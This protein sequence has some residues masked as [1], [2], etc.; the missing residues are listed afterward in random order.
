MNHN[1]HIERIKSL[2]VIGLTILLILSNQT[3]LLSAEIKPIQ[4]ND[5]IYF[6]FTF[7]NPEITKTNDGVIFSLLNCDLTSFPGSPKIPFKSVKILIPQNKDLDSIDVNNGDSFLFPETYMLAH[8]QRAIPIGNNIDNSYTPQNLDIYNSNVEFPGHFY[9]IISIE[10]MC[11]FKVLFVNIYPVQ[12]IPISGEIYLYPEI[13]LTVNLKTNDDN[14]IKNNNFRMYPKDVERIEKLVDNSDLINT[15]TFNDDISFILSSEDSFVD[16]ADTYEYVVITNKELRDASGMD[17]NFWDLI[18]SKLDKGMNATIVTVE[19]IVNCSTYWWDGAFGDGYPFFNDTA[20]KIRNFIK[21]AYNN[22]ETLYVL[23]GGD[24]DATYL[25]DDDCNGNTCPPYPSDLSG[26]NIIPPRNLMSTLVFGLPEITPSDLYYGALNG[27]WNKPENPNPVS[28]DLSINEPSVHGSSEW[29]LDGP[30]INVTDYLI[31]SDS[32]QWTCTNTD[33]YYA[34]CIFNIDDPFM[35]ISGKS[36]LN[37]QINASDNDSHLRNVIINSNDGSEISFYAK[38]LG[39][40]ASLWDL[41]ENKWQSEHLFLETFV[42]ISDFNWSNVISITIEIFNPTPEIG[43]T[44]LLDGV[45]FSEYVDDYWGEPDEADL[46]NEVIIGRAPVDSALEVSNFVNKTLAYDSSDGEDFLRDVWMVGEQVYFGGPA[47]WGANYKDEIKYGS[48]NYGYSTSGISVDYDV[49]TIYDRDKEFKQGLIDISSYCGND[50]VQL[51]FRAKSDNNIQGAGFYI[52]D[53][54]IICDDNNVVFFDDMENEESEWQIDGF[55]ENWERGT[56]K[57]IRIWARTDEYNRPIYETTSLIGFSGAICWGTN[58]D[59]LYENDINESILSPIFDL[60][61]FSTGKLYFSYYYNFEENFD[62]GYVEISVDN[63][64]TW[65]ILKNYTSDSW[66]DKNDLLKAFNDNNP[67]IINHLG[68]GNNYHVMK[69]DEPLKMRSQRNCSSCTPYKTYGSCHDITKNLT[70]IKPFFMYSQACLPGAF[71]N[72]YPPHPGGVHDKS[73]YL[74]NDSIIEYMLTDENG[75]F[76]CV[77]NTRFGLGAPSTNAPS[78]YFDREFFDALFSE[79]NK[80]FGEAFTDSLKYNIGRINNYGIRYCFYETTY[81]GDPE[82]CIKNP[83]PPEHDLCIENLTNPDYGVIEEDVVFNITVYNRGINEENNV[84]INFY[85]ND[86]LIDSIII[87]NIDSFEKYLL[88]FSYDTVIPGSYHLKFEVENV[89]GESYIYDN[90]R[91]FDFTIYQIQPLKVVILES[92]GTSFNFMIYDLL[93]LRWQEFIDTPVIIDYISLAHNDITLDDL[94]STNAD[95]LVIDWALHTPQFKMFDFEYSDE[96]LDAI[97]DYINSGH[98][99]I[100]TRDSF[101]GNNHRLKPFVGL[102]PDISIIDIYKSRIGK[103]NVQQ[104]EHPMFNNLPNN[105]LSKAKSCY[106]RNDTKWDEYDIDDGTIMALSDNLKGIIVANDSRVYMSTWIHMDPVGNVYVNDND[107]QLFYNTILYANDPDIAN[108]LLV[109]ANLPNEGYI[110]VP[111]NFNCT[112]K[113]GVEPYNFSWDFGD[114]YNS[115]SQNTTHIYQS[116][117]VYNV[118]LTVTDTTGN[119]S[120]DKKQVFISHQPYSTLWVNQDYGETTPGWQ[121]DHFNTIQEAIDLSGTFGTIHVYNGTYKENLM[122]HKSV[123]LIG[124]DKNNT[125]IDGCQQ[126]HVINISA[127]Y[128]NISEFTIKNSSIGQG[129]NEIGG[130]Y[131][132]SKNLNISDNIILNNDIGIKISNS[133]NSL[134]NNNT[135]LNNKRYGIILYDTKFTTVINN[136][137]SKNVF[138]GLVLLASPINNIL[139]NQ[140]KYNSGNGIYSLFSYANIIENNFISYN[141]ADGVTL[142]D[143]DSNIIFFNNISNNDGTSIQIYESNQNNIQNN[144]IIKN[145]NGGFV[146]TFS[147]LNVLSKNVILNNDDLGI[148]LVGE[149]NFPLTIYNNISNNLIK[150]NGNNG[151]I[152]DESYENIIYNNTILNHSLNGIYFE[153]SDDNQITNNTI[154]Y[155]QKGVKIVANSYQNKIQANFLE[156]NSDGIFIDNSNINTIVKNKIRN[157]N[158]GIYLTGSDNSMIGENFIV[159][160]SYGIYFCD[161]SLYNSVIWNVIKNNQMYGMYLCGESSDNTIY[162]NTFSNINNAY[163][164]VGYNQYYIFIYY[165]NHPINQG[166]FWQDYTGVDNDGDDIGDTPYNISGGNNKDYYPLIFPRAFPPDNLPPDIPSKASG[167]T[168]KLMANALYLYS[169]VTNDTDRDKVYYYFNWG[170]KSGSGWIGPYPSGQPVALSHAWRSPGTYHIRVKAKD[171]YGEITPFSETL[172]INVGGGHIIPRPSR[173]K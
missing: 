169:S 120:T 159:N 16:P 86:E 18:D 117:D 26:D 165:P 160:N 151:I 161:M 63:G 23:L 110:N 46:L 156:F 40:N 152:F 128:V 104:P 65:N 35:D 137:I 112:V 136:N 22:W 24:G 138:E 83:P 130:I 62:F 31:G 68:H 153:G 126:N 84:K 71:D 87:E 12:Y 149:N 78:Q 41:P 74:E 14:S 114:G 29:F 27:S 44:I 166:N 129:M 77:A 168:Q 55:S 111:I 100:V 72:V 148:Y 105:F 116:I 2:L 102:N 19:D 59:G 167:P 108:Q 47:E 97:I 124:E 30:T 38:D 42:G 10:E 162:H 28:K 142:G 109:S 67:H 3:L 140:I 150:N 54:K 94:N 61:T 133:T 69:L 8:G 93:N 43:D 4:E 25:L 89:S 32:L 50:N 154:K 6:N 132:T 157:C 7:E 49:Y 9:E 107:L 52:D 21:D 134:I 98:G 172:T 122:V 115:Y 145:K 11:G 92:M 127:D 73:W 139:N 79:D 96:E 36:W 113:N 147:R 143:S 173:D 80:C 82:V 37:F 51:R 118:T 88:S 163:D 39:I 53:V 34:R 5:S 75:L 90:Y 15:Y 141:K 48:D 91:E 85:I 66:W 135:I 164:N 121:Q 1:L 33:Y 17:Y 57:N 60:S 81:F 171:I 45:Y 56:P 76:A 101:G 158:N 106:P 125:I 64:V 144:Q 58:I 119:I 146:I 131:T 103:I 13:E 155:S 20:C 123:N 99:L 95:V 70:N 170:D